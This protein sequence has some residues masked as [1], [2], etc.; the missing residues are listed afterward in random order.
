MKEIAA[1]AKEGVGFHHELCLLPRAQPAGQQGEQETLTPFQCRAFHLSMKGDQLRTQESA[2]DS[3]L[4][5]A[6]SE[7]N[8]GIRERSVVVWPDP[9]SV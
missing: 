6:A 4:S 2:L 7:I 1:L 3:M 9:A 5:S 8:G